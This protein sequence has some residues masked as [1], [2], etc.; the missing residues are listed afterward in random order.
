VEDIKRLRE[1]INKSNS[2]QSLYLFIDK[3]FF[4]KS[5]HAQ[6]SKKLKYKSK[7]KKDK[8]QKK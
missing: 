2:F 4:L 1:S 7:M 8:N 3:I 6:S 5:T